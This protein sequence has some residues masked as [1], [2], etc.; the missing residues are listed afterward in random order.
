MM[1]MMRK[2]QIQGVEKGNVKGQVTFNA[3]L[4]GVAA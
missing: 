4:F 2:G 1:H 3:S